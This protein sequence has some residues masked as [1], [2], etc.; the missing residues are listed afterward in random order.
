MDLLLAIQKYCEKLREYGLYPKTKNPSL[1]KLEKMA[2]LCMA[3]KFQ[4][5]SRYY[6]KVD[7][8]A[9][10]KAELDLLMDK[11]KEIVKNEKENA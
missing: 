11:I 10:K 2:D 3:K 4:K 9:E 7:L 1:G 8:D 5:L 6:T